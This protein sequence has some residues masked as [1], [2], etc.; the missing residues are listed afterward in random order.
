LDWAEAEIVKVSAIAKTK[1]NWEYWS[2]VGVF[3][4]RTKL[5]MLRESL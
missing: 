4:G 1:A 2:G 5:R 3:M